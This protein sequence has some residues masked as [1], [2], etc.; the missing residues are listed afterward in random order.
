MNHPFSLNISDL[1]AIE[2]SF[3]EH[4]ED[5]ES[6]QVMGGR[7][8]ATTDALGEEGGIVCIS[9]PCPGSE[10]GD[11]PL[12]KPLPKPYP[13]KPPVVTTLAIGEEG[14]S[15]PQSPVTKAW[16]EVGGRPSDSSVH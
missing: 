7:K 14:G 9:A 6:S 2:F 11:V 12:P 3:E 15:Y 4:L 5:D 13:T 10:G 16:L 8:I 1:E